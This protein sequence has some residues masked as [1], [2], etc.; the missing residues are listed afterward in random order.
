MK[1]LIIIP[2]LLS[3]FGC[4]SSSKAFIESAKERGTPLVVS[5]VEVKYPNSAGGVGL[6]IHFTNTSNRTLKYIVFSVEPYNKVGDIAPSEIG[7]KTLAH[8]QSIGPII[9]GE[10][11]GDYDFGFIAYRAPTWLNVWYN[12]SIYCINL[13]GIDITYMG[14]ETVSFDRTSLHELMGSSVNSYVC[15]N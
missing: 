15:R 13:I 3:I 12:H 9:S 6:R 2:I 5:R 14:G 1:K 4:A 7:G 10:Y 8:L 11:R